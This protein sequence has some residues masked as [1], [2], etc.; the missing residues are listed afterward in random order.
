MGK[1]QSWSK[2]LKQQ[3]REGQRNHIIRT[4]RVTDEMR[5]KLRK[6]RQAIGPGASG[7]TE[8]QDVIEWIDHLVTMVQ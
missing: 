8:L 3:E 6:A 1:V 5:A 2:H 7:Y 4:E